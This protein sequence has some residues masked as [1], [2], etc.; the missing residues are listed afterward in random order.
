MHNNPYKNYSDH[1]AR[2]KKIKN[3]RYFVLPKSL[4]NLHY[5]QPAYISKAK[6]SQSIDKS[7]NHSISISF[8]G[9]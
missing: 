9:E 1:Y 6:L 3:N 7:L 2:L 4:K 8:N 5:D